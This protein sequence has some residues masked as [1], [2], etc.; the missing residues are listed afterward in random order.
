MDITE[1]IKP[2]QLTQGFVAF[3]SGEDFDA[4]SRFKWCASVGRGGRVVAVRSYRE[5]G[6]TITV[7]MH[8]FIAKPLGLHVDHI[9]R[10]PL[11]NVRTN[12]RLVTHAI[13]RQNTSRQ[14]NNKSGFKG[15]MRDK[16]S[17]QWIA[18]IRAFGVTHHLGV[19]CAA[20]SAARA[21]DDAAIRLLGKLAATNF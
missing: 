12:L 17:G 11:N 1:I 21:Y 20:E 16:R 4:V 15:V 7:L 8:R 9:D 2:I 13:N 19:H 10:N 18:R 6:K 3:V 14:K 5:N